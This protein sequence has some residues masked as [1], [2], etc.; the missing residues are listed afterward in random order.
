MFK[1]LF[2]LSYFRGNL[3]WE[4]LI[5]GRNFALQNGLGLTIRTASTNSPWA[6]I[7]KGLLS[8]GFVRLRFG[9]LIF[10]RAYFWGGLL[11]EFYGITHQQWYALVRVF[12]IFHLQISIYRFLL[13]YN[14]TLL[15]GNLAFLS[16][17]GNRYF[18]CIEILFLTT[19]SSC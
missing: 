19:C 16:K 8:E 15:S 13:A 14:I 12:S 4:G 17:T 3:F 7:R 11:L 5:I 10:R 2:C 9:G 18:G 1:G 6:Y